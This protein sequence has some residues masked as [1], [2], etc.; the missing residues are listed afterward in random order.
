MCKWKGGNWTGLVVRVNG[1]VNVL[2]DSPFPLF[3][4]KTGENVRL[5][6]LFLHLPARLPFFCLFFYLFLHQ[7]LHDWQIPTRQ[8]QTILFF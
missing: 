8:L 6:C 3:G 7:L 2:L 1:I 5:I 4:M